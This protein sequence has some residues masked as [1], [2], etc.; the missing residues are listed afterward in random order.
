MCQSGSELDHDKCIGILRKYGFLPESHSGFRAVDLLHVPD[1]LNEEDLEMLLREKGEEI[2]G[3]RASSYSRPVH[4]GGK[5]V[6]VP[7]SEY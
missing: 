1:N 7:M 4:S 5:Y 6:Q 3:P 2:C